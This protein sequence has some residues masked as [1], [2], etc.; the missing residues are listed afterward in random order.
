MNISIHSKGRATI[1]V[2]L[3]IL[4]QYLALQESKT[5]TLYKVRRFISGEEMVRQTELPED[6]D[7]I[8]QNL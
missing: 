8:D 1:A 2:N 3:L 4:G 5:V 7:F 6:I